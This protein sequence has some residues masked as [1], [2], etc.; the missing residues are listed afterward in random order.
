MELSMND[1]A[2][3]EKI[4]TAFQEMGVFV[5]SATSVMPDG[6]LWYHVRTIKG[7]SPEQGRKI[8]QIMTSK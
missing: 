2:K 8:M 4:V 5:V 3:F 7:V 1:S 6:E